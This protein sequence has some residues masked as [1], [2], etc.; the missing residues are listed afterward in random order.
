MVRSTSLISM[1]RLMS[2]QGKAGPFPGPLPDRREPDKQV[3]HGGHAIGFVALAHLQRSR[4]CGSC[5]LHALSWGAQ[6]RKE[7]P[8][9]EN[10]P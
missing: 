9:Q 4:L 5:V 7:I 3:R 10:A 6:A 1:T 8:Q 2:L